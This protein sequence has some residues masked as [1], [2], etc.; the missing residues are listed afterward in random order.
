LNKCIIERDKNQPLFNY[1]Y[2]AILALEV[3]EVNNSFHL[4]FMIKLTKY[5]G[6]GI[7]DHKSFVR[8]SNNLQ[9]YDNP[10]TTRILQKLLESDLTEVPIMTPGQRA[11]ILNDIV[12]Y[13]YTHLDMPPLKS[14]EVLR[15]VFK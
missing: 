9:F 14:L 2:N 3:A 5:L 4:Q 7:H 13:Y 8:Q 15:T 11:N 12:Q 1:L 10:E 6:F